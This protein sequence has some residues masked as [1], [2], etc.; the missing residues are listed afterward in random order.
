MKIT[1][2]TIL[3]SFLILGLVACD[4][5][6]DD[7]GDTADSGVTEDSENEETE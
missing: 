1:V 3:A 7:T 4:D 5:K 2:N 6:D